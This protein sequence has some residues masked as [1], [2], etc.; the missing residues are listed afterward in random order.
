MSRATVTLKT[1]DGQTEAS[2]FRPDSGEGP[3]PAVLV[4]QDGRGIRPALFELGE[5]IAQGGYFVLLPDLFYRAG[6]YEAPDAEA[7]SRDPELRKQW[8]QKY[9]STAT[10][11]NVRSDT[12]AFLA[13]LAAQPD[14][15]SLAI[16]TTGYCMGG[17]LSLS[18][19]GHFPDRVIAAASYHG[20]N[21]ATDDPESPH[22]LAP[23]IRARVYVAG[24]V[25]DASFPDQ[26]KQR[27]TEAFEQAGVQ[28]T[29]E[30]YAGAKHGWVPSDS[31]VYNRD[32]SERHYKTLLALF[33][34]T[35]K[36]APPKN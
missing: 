13:F 3:W 6:P 26:Q 5:R 31:S 18:A 32:A 27:L 9:M 15:R 21:L 12:E 23:R 11:A 33:D 20:G 17:G 22:L 29:V 30:T 36:S 34:A 2:V 8:Q 16:G 7:F 19:A 10:K 24:A 14:V 1:R 4:Y 35:L 25:E 28:H